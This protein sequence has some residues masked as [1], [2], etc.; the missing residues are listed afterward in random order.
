MSALAGADAMTM[1]DYPE[2]ELLKN[3]QKNVD[4]NLSRRN[5]CKTIVRGHTWGEIDS[6]WALEN[7]GRFT[8]ILVAD[9]LWMPEQHQNLARSI[10]H[11]LSS[12]SRSHALV[13]AG[14]HSGRDRMA[15]FFAVAVEEGLEVTEI[16]EVDVEG[17]ARMWQIDR[18]DENVFERKR[19]LAVAVL[20]RK[21]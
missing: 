12:A 5:K 13:V 21:P 11:F 16:S 6:Q 19:W 7:A 10:A 9:C 2:P 14:F 8:R 4:A 18:G 15:P 20:R 3:M 17:N 1:T